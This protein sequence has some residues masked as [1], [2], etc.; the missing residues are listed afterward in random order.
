MSLGIILPTASQHYYT[1]YQVGHAILPLCSKGKSGLQQ[2][3]PS[4][5]VSPMFRI[6]RKGP[7]RDDLRLEADAVLTP[8]D[9]SRIAEET[10]TQVV[11][12]RKTGFVAARRASKSEA[13]ETR[14]N[15]K[16]SHDTARAGDWIVTNLTP[17]QA[18]L[19]D[20]EGHVNT[21]VILAERFASLYEATGGHTEFGAINRAKGTVEA[22]RLPGGFDI[23]APWGERQTSPAGYLLCNGTDVYG[24]N[25][26][27]FAV[28]YEV[29]C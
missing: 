20:R 26:E 14:W 8:A 17:Q 22:I 1:T 13:V 16:E 4:Q 27:T 28:T 3:L 2:R 25:A 23:V 12:A 21:Y 6:V 5:R 18:A 11:H 7:G 24:N 19:R 15:G 9:F 29:V 10:R